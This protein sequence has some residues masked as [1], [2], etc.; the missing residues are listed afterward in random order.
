MKNRSIAFAV[1]FQA[2]MCV[3]ISGI[4]LA[5]QK[6]KS[7]QSKLALTFNT[8]LFDKI[9]ILTAFFV[10]F[11]M[12][13]TNLGIISGVNFVMMTMIKSSKCLSATLLTFLFPPKG[14]KRTVSFANVIFGVVITLGLILFNMK[15]SLHDARLYLT[16]SLY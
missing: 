8:M 12:F 6:T 15:V 4:Y 10:F 1:G 11:G 14:A 7:G 2:L 16:F 5:L 9:V 3:F 13:L